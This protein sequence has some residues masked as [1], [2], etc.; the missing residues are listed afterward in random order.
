[1]AELLRGKEEQKF[2]AGAVEGGNRTTVVVSVIIAMD[3]IISSVCSLRFKEEVAAF[4]DEHIGWDSLHMLTLEF[5]TIGHVE[6]SVENQPTKSSAKPTLLR[7]ELHA[8]QTETRKKMEKRMRRKRVKKKRIRR[9]KRK[10][11]RGD[12]EMRVSGGVGEGNWDLGLC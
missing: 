12:E 11:R 7:Q 8:I 10:W 2:A 9:K 1:M 4:E 5:P 3:I 6:D